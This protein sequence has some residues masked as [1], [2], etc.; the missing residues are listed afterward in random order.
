MLK[1]KIRSFLSKIALSKVVNSNQLKFTVHILN[2]TLIINSED[3]EIVD[4]LLKQNSIKY[5]VAL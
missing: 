1:L 3:L 4:K 5:T 2:K